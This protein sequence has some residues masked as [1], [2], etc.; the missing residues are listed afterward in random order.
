M[1][2]TSASSLLVVREGIALDSAA[3]LITKDSGLTEQKTVSPRFMPLTPFFARTTPLE[4]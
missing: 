1:L 2:F 3:G 4:F